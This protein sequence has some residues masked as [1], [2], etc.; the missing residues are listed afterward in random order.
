[1]I[2]A[3][4]VEYAPG[5]YDRLDMFDDEKITLK[6]K[7]KDS[8]DI[9][10]M[11]STYSQTFT[12]PASDKNN[13][14]LDYFFDTT[15]VRSST[16][17]VNAKLYVNDTLFK[18]GKI[19]LNEAA[20]KHNSQTNYN[21]NFF[22][23]L[24]TLKD[25]VGDDLLSEVF[26]NNKCLRAWTPNSLSYQ[27]GS[28]TFT[29]SPGSYPVRNFVPLASKKRVWTFGDG[30]PNDIKWNGA[31]T[32]KLIGLD[33]VRP[34]VGLLDVLLIV[35]QHYNINIDISDFSDDELINTY[36]HCNGP[37]FRP[38]PF[39]YRFNAPGGM[40]NINSPQGPYTPWNTQIN[41]TNN[42]IFE[43]FYIE[44]PNTQH[45]NAQVQITL[46]PVITAP[47]ADSNVIKYKIIDKRPATFGNI[48]KD[49][50]APSYT[51]SSGQ[52]FFAIIYDVDP[53]ALGMNTNS[54]VPM[55]FSVEIDSNFF[56]T[57]TQSSANFIAT[58]DTAGYPQDFYQDGISQNTSINIPN[59]NI[60]DFLQGIPKIKVID[61]LS[62]LFKMF[63]ARVIEPLNG[64]STISYWIDGKSFYSGEVDYSDYVNSETHTIKPPDV[65]K[66]LSFSHK[67]G[68]YKSSVDYALVN[69]NNPNSKEYAQLLYSTTNQYDKNTYD[70]KTAFTV[71]PNVKI[72]GSN[73]VTW[74][75]F[76]SD[77]GTAN[78]TYGTIYKAN[79][80]DFT[81][82]CFNGQGSV[83]NTATGGFGSIGIKD[84]IGNVS[85]YIGVYNLTSLATSYTIT[86]FYDSLG[87]KDEVSVA[88][89]NF[90]YTNNLYSKFYKSDINRLY[91]PN[92]KIFTFEGYLPADK[93]LS[94]SLRNLIIIGNQKYTIEEADIDITTG[95]CKLVLMNYAPVNVSTSIFGLAPIPPITIQ[96]EIL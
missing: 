63:N 11:F 31:N 10:K 92:T 23:G 80:E 78:A 49:A 56:F 8:A 45:L 29:I 68:K 12:V 82:F 93:I 76:T 52:L 28:E 66:T 53:Y 59:F 81:I 44:D 14:L 18:L 4:Y 34:A 65:Y 24:S 51:N 48:L 5:E 19:G 41:P 35:F 74:Y 60:T 13:R 43:I 17:Y 85:P 72:L 37:N 96:T 83:I 15:V 95:K 26:G 25:L 2:V 3:I 6:F 58:F 64:T 46:Y 71:V 40:Q 89:N 73:M 86:P 75:A 50:I 54:Q 30:G 77:D 87:F 9:G 79:T 20:M 91:N 69:T 27:L 7:V 47:N 32:T 84:V 1:M 57:Y 16:K 42:E 55:K 67:Q 39:T 38:L 21:I 90:I 22:T 88:N 61:F 62:S 33:E 36:I 70:V 94:F